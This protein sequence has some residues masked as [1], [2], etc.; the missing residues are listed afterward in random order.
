[1]KI[2]KPVEATLVCR[3]C[4]TVLGELWDHAVPMRAVSYRDGM[5]T[6]AVTSSAWSHEVSQ[7][8][9]VLKERANYQLGG[10]PINKVRTKV[11]PSAARGEIT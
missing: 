11:A 2:R 9:E 3:A 4:D 8:I 1:M 5:V 7:N 10:A 6:V